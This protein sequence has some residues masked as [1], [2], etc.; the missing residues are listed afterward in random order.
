MLRTVRGVK[1]ITSLLYVECQ[2]RARDTHVR[3]GVH[4][5][6]IVYHVVLVH[7]Q[8]DL[9]VRG[10]LRVLVGLVGLVGL[11]GLVGQAIRWIEGWQ[12]KMSGVAAD[13]GSGTWFWS[14]PRI[15]KA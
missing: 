13:H 1:R 3:V 15:V 10:Y 2:L 14:A 8:Q 6:E 7:I 12:D 11:E 9:C 4:A 5:V